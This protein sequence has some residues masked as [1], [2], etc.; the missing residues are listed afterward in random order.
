MIEKP[1]VRHDNVLNFLVGC[2]LRRGMGLVLPLLVPLC[3]QRP[4]AH[5]LGS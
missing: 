1:I 4:I 3:D 5:R 2:E